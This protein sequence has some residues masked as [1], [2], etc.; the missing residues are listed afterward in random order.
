MTA[1]LLLALRGMPPEETPR[2]WDELFPAATIVAA[3]EEDVEEDEDE[4]I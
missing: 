2:P 1:R 4:S 3:D